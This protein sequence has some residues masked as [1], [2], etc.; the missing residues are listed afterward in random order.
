MVQDVQVKVSK[1]AHELGEGLKKFVL[2]IKGALADGWQPGADI[3]VVLSAAL[4]DLVPAVQGVEKIK[5]ETKEDL[6][7]FVSA[8]VLPAK[9]LAFA[10]L[11]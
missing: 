8:L 4:A 1:E 6:E 7:A 5:D 11:K 2:S 9:E 3:P 10:L